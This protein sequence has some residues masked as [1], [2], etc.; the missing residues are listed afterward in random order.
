MK[1]STL[2]LHKNWEGLRT[3]IYREKW[4]VEISHGED[5]TLLLTSLT[6][7]TKFVLI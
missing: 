2:L 5:N 4:D 7:R 3:Y 1:E 6:M